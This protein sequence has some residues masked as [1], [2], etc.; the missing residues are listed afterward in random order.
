[1]IVGCDVLNKMPPITLDF[2]NQRV[3]VGTLSF[4]ML[5][6]VQRAQT[7]K[8][9]A[10]EHITLMPGEQTLVPCEIVGHPTGGDLLI[11]QP[12]E[13]LDSMNIGLVPGVFNA[14]L[15]RLLVPLTNPCMDPKQIF[16]RTT[17]AF[18]KILHTDITHNLLC[19]PIFDLTLQQIEEIPISTENIDPAYKIDF[20][21]S[22][23][24]GNNL[25]KLQQ[26]VDKYADVFSKSQYDLGSCKVGAH[27]I[28]TSTEEPVSSKPHRTPFRYKEE[29]DKHIQ[30][31]LDS[32]VIIES[33]TP[34]V[35]NLVLVKK[36][37][38]SLRP[39]IDFRKLNEI[40]IPDRYPLPRFDVILEK[41]A[42]CHYYSS[43]DLSSGYFQIALTEEASRKCG[44]ITEDKI[45]QTVRMP[46]GLRNATSA[47]ARTMALVLSGLDES[48]L[49]YVDDTLVFTPSP[50]FEDHLKALEAVFERFRLYNLKLHPKK[51]I[52]GASE[53][54]F[55]G[56]TINSH[57]YAP[58]LAKVEVI[59]DI[60]APTNLKQVRRAVGM[61]S[62]FRRH[63]PNF[64]SIVEPLTRLT[65]KENKFSWG[66]E[67]AKAL[68]QVKELLSKEPVLTF[69]NY[70][71]PFHIFA[72]ASLVGQ[73]GALMQKDEKGQFKA[74]AY[75]SRTLSTAERRWPPVQVE[76]AAII[77]ALREFKGFIY[78]SE[79]ELHSDHK[80]LSFL[81]KKAE[82]APNLARWLIE[83]Q[84]YN[85]KIVH[86]NGKE[87]SLADALSRVDEDVP[88]KH[89]ESLKEMD[90]IA[91]F[92]ICFALSLGPRVVLDPFISRI[93]LR[94][95]AG[96]PFT[97]DL[98]E[99]QQKDPECNYIIQYLKDGTYPPG[100]TRQEES[101]FHMSVE[102]AR[103]TDGIL[104]YHKTGQPVKLHIP[105]SLRL[106]I[107]ET[108]HSSPLGG[109]H[110][111]YL[112]T[113]DKISRRYFW[114]KM[115]ADILTWVK[116]C[117][118]CQLNTKPSSSHRAEM[119]SVPV[120]T[121]FAKLGLDLTGP[122]P[123]SEKGNKYILNVICWFSKYVISIPVPDTKSITV[124]RALLQNVYLKFGGCTHL[125]SDNATTFTSD[126]F[127]TFCR[128]MYVNKTYSTPYHSEGNGITERTFRTFHSMLRKY[129]DQNDHNFEDMLDCATFAYNTCTHESTKESPYFLLFGR[130]PIF[131]IE[132]MLDPRIRLN[133]STPDLEFKGKLVL[134]L[135]DAWYAAASAIDEAHRKMKRAYDKKTRPIDIAVGDKVLLR[136][137]V[138]VPGSA[139]KW[140]SPWR[141]IFR[142]IN[143]DDIHVT[144]VSCACPQ[145]NPFRVHIN[146]I[147][148]FH[149][150]IGPAC[151]STQLSEEEEKALR[152]ALAVE[153]PGMPGNSHDLPEI[154][155]GSSV[156][157]PEEEEAIE[158]PRPY[159][160]RPRAP[161]LA[162]TLSQD[163][164]SESDF[165]ICNFPLD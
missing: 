53:M 10:L 118:P 76:L 32:K 113:I 57:G 155:G 123:Q 109:G 107:F 38:G 69:P 75:C 34:W 26:L 30:K 159:N 100:M 63:I 46:F 116:H 106:I 52:L 122:L 1:M 29:L 24:T 94:D 59:K 160:L 134:C 58:S 108:F 65:K 2:Q 102:Y 8:I 132:H 129:L 25:H 72:D 71:K 99:E 147:K 66:R 79:I 36:K 105:I 50:N 45:Y 126:F 81:M 15:L 64:S 12:A 165:E 127:R 19:E 142:V 62:F 83:L 55:L 27:H 11:D 120:N 158:K 4:P 16:K 33:D 47:F 44:I 61:A 42:H 31:L 130:D 92:P 22:V 28:E 110:M 54:Q 154:Q 95:S 74:I 41:I 162:L 9:R 151:T 23:V 141:G 139:K 101:R 91:E 7:Y 40:T 150:P 114:P 43:L 68:D 125:V 5:D 128:L 156:E 73:G 152:E 124:A 35:S 77:Y 163:D 14:E 90:D 88:I 137:Y 131:N 135:R 103:Y 49:A 93:T 6:V 85:V 67:Q 48:V 78:M 13:R 21:K 117:V 149:E 143:I 121:V 146:Q 37:D 161:K 136:N 138:I 148:L 80:P 51:C 144:I 20:S 56:Y 157:M 115:N 86:I 133:Y 84:N 89:V 164:V 39:C 60:P 119:R 111:S 3:A 98:K 82:S 18:A 140:Q 87:N 112:K 153:L 97:F 96:H 70:D 145:K 104:Y 17:I